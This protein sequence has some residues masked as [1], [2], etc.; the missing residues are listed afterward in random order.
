MGHLF[1]LL[2]LGGFYHGDLCSERL[3]FIFLTLW[4]HLSTAVI[5]LMWPRWCFLSSLAA[6]ESSKMLKSG[7]LSW[8]QNTTVV[9]FKG[10]NL[11]FLVATGNGGRKKVVH[12]ARDTTDKRRFV[13]IV[14]G[15]F[16]FCSVAAM[17]LPIRHPTSALSWYDLQG[18]GILIFATNRGKAAVSQLDTRWHLSLV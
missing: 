1:L 12:T 4:W 7:K 2:F 17:L 15:N 16:V 3:F 11:F 13:D 5:D 18:A 14:G 8:K 9:K 6:S 10:L